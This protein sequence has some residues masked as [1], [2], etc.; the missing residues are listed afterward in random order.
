[1]DDYSFNDAEEEMESLRL[2]NRVQDKIIKDMR[3]EY[4]KALESAPSFL[5][6]D[7]MEKWNRLDEKQKEFIE[8]F[9]KEGES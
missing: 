5:C 3:R 9:S 4:K 6:K 2:E 7:C 8:T 1:M